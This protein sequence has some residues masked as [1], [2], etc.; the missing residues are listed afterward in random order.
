MNLQFLFYITAFVLLKFTAQCQ[1]ESNSIKLL[2][3]NLVN[4]P[5]AGI[6]IVKKQG[7]WIL[8][9]TSPAKNSV[10]MMKFRH[11]VMD[12]SDYQ[13]LVCNVK[14]LSSIPQLVEMG[15]NDVLR[16]TGATV[17]LPNQT[18]TLKAIIIKDDNSTNKELGV[19]GLDN[20]AAKL[21]YTTHAETVKGINFVFP[22][23]YGSMKLEIIDIR[24]EKVLERSNIL[25]EGMITSKYYA[26]I[27]EFGQYSK[28][29]YTGK[30][31]NITDLIASKNKERIDINKN[32]PISNRD[33]YG[34]WMG[35]PQFKITGTFQVTRYNGKWWLIDPLGK[36][37][38][39]S[40]VD[41]INSDGFTRI[42]GRKE[43]FSNMNLNS[44]D[45]R[46]YKANSDGNFFNFVASN[47]S[48]KYGN[49]WSDSLNNITQKRLLSWGINTIGNWSDPAI[50]RQHRVPYVGTITNRKQGRFKM[51]DPFD[52]LFETELRNTINIKFAALANDPWCIGFFVDNELPWSAISDVLTE[53]ASQPAK[54]AFQQMLKK[55]YR[56]ICSLNDAWN[57][58]FASWGDLLQSTN[59][60]SILEKN[61]DFENFYNLFAN[62]YFSKVR[63]ILKRNAPK[64]LY[65]GCRFDFQFY[66]SDT[67]FVQF[68]SIAAKYC[69]IVSFN[70]YRYTAADLK[71][72]AG[73]FPII[74]G[75]FQFGAL[76]RGAFL[77]G[78]RYVKSQKER[79]ALYSY[80][81]HSALTNPYIVGAHWFQYYDEPLTGRADGENFQMGFLS[82]TDNPYYDL[83]DSVRK[84][85]KQLYNIRTNAK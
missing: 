7:K 27:D 44:N 63:S 32:P 73:N 16:S 17:V 49:K 18:K 68:V 77:P 65:L 76:D 55:K 56:S 75:E 70:R 71:P 66:P 81:I 2:D 6:S 12:F 9:S 79:G 22:D 20:F 28:A 80:Y 42:N 60:Y 48:K 78:F 43:L 59:R 26:L 58:S 53:E 11:G 30:I 36:L 72:K 62:T 10:F 39:S 15:F 45:R 46:I 3:S 29:N 38:W 52:E 83:T 64:K 57:T 24:L 21:W 84:I 51:P 61:V 85:N 54:L 33:Q 41:A 69:D 19:Y 74:I 1:V 40:G 50:Y 25:K 23:I 37:F 82:I 8:T 13:Y 34:G 31:R 47:L 35:G 4:N 5:T 67:R 14:N